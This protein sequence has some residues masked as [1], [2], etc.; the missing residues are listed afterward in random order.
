MNFNFYGSREN[1]SDSIR[2]QNK[3]ILEAVEIKE[4]IKIF[5]HFNIF[6]GGSWEFLKMFGS[7]LSYSLFPLL[8]LTIFDSIECQEI[9]NFQR[10]L[11]NIQCNIKTSTTMSRK[12]SLSIIVSLIFS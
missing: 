5:L 6:S 12:S 4:N 10:I 2:S 3:T 1:K 7:L 11:Q 8:I 9:G